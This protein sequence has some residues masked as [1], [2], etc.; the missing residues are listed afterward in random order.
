MVVANKHTFA[1]GF[2]QALP[3]G[4][5]DEIA[6][7]FEAAEYEPLLSRL[8]QYRHTGRKG[9]PIPAMWRAYQLQD[10]MSI[11]YANALVKILRS[12]A[13]LRGLCGFGDQAPS[14]SAISRFFARIKLH[15][16]LVDEALNPVHDQLADTIDESRHNGELPPNSPPLGHIIAIDSTDIPAWVDTQKE[17]FSDPEARWG[18]RT[19]PKAPGGE[20]FFYGYKLHLICDAHYGVPLTYEVLPANRN[21]SPTLPRL[22]DKLMKD[23]PNIRPRY[24]LADKGYDALSNHK[25]LDDLGIIPII[26]LRDT[27]KEGIYDKKGRPTC[28]GGKPMEYVGTDPAKGHLFRCRQKGCRLKDKIGLTTYCDIEYYEDLEGDALRKVGR[29]VRTTK[30][31]KKLYRMRTVIERLFRSLKQSRWLS[32]HQYRGLEK[33]RLHASFALLTCSTTMLVRAQDGHYDRIR[34]MR[35]YLPTT[36][37][38]PVEQMWLAV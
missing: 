6:R 26:P 15:Q 32:G 2:G 38:A 21:D 5:Y 3:A 11:R 18:H 12:D 28:F 8:Q 17:P 1:D 13:R 9:Y 27:D 30:R 24:L 35:I 10:L 37:Q 20:E 4:G 7:N 22:I 19:N 36:K 23:H 25:H 33:V 16:D 31:W 29:L 34:R 14:E